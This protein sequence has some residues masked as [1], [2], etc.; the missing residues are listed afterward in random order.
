MAAGTHETHHSSTGIDNRKLLM[1]LFLASECLFFGSLIA[2]YLVYQDRITGTEFT[3]E[4]LFDVQLTTISTFILLMSSLSMV[5][6]V[7]AVQHHQVKFMRL[8]LLTTMAAGVGFLAIQAYD[9]VHLWTHYHFDP[10]TNQFGAT[11][12]M[13]TGFH[14][15][16]VIVGLIYLGSMLIGSMRRRGLGDDAELHIDIGG[17]YWHFVDLAWIVIFTVVFL[18]PSTGAI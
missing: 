13:L 14:K 1:W 10:T 8:M 3:P 9:W 17:L 6:A 15:A 5:L 7:Y 12:Y 2:S 18:I 4:H 11:F 16:H